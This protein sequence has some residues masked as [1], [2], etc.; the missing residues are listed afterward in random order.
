MPTDRLQRG[1]SGWARAGF[2][3]VIATGWTFTRD[4]RV[5]RCKAPLAFSPFISHCRLRAH[6]SCPPF[7]LCPSAR[8]RAGRAFFTDA[9]LACNVNPA[10]V[11]PGIGPLRTTD[12]DCEHARPAEGIMAFLKTCLYFKL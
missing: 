7:A 12:A 9:A 4:S 6:K 11:L 5:R 8:C 3:G 10:R 2:S 1:T